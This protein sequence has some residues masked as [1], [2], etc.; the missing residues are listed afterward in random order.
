MNYLEMQSLLALANL[1]A[2]A[3]IAWSCVCR[4]KHMNA[5]D[6][7]KDVRAA[8]VFTMGAAFASG[9]SPLLWREWPGI[10]QTWLAWAVLL[11]LFVG[12]REWRDG[13]PRY[14]QSRPASLTQY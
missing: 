7:R 11:L 5:K 10:G 9:F 1:V 2:C 14:A 8:V 4:M 13:L 12:A 6:A 3:G